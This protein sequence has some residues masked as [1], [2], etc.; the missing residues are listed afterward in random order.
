MLV[1]SVSINTI[2]PELTINGRTLDGIFAEIRGI[3]NE[4]GAFGERTWYVGNTMI[5]V[6]M[7]G[8]SVGEIPSDLPQKIYVSDSPAGAGTVRKMGSAIMDFIGWTG[9]VDQGA[10]I[11]IDGNAFSSF[12]YYSS[13]SECA[14]I[15]VKFLNDTLR[16]LK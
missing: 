13:C 6:Y 16:T 5:H 7:D 8:I 15:L 1:A 3:K 14:N 4:Y 12:S 9:N 11:V 10:Y 2:S